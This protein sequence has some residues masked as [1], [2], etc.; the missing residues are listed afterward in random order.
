MTRLDEIENRRK[1]DVI[2][3]LRGMTPRKCTHP[4]SWFSR[5]IEICEHGFEGMHNYCTECGKC[6]DFHEINK[7]NKGG[8]EK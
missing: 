5:C 3:G 4:D 7:G 6:V 8:K 2:C 1:T